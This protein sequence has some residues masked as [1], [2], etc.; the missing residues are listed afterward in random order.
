MRCFQKI[1][2][3]PFVITRR[4]KFNVQWIWNIK[5][6]KHAPYNYVLYK[7]EFAS[8]KTCPTCGLSRFKKKIDGNSGDEDK[9][10]VHAKV[11]LYLPIIPRFK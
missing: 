5:R 2:C 6:Y 8:L 3:Y 4:T 9:N 10:Y 7:D 11:M 1:K